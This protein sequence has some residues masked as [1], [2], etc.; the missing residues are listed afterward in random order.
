[1][2]RVR[3]RQL[4]ESRQRG[5]IEAVTVGRTKKNA[6]MKNWRLRSTELPPNVLLFS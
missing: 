5:K 2:N 4:G 3:R 6:P 1:M